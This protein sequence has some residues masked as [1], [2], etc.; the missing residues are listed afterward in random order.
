MFYFHLADHKG[1][2]TAQDYNTQQVSTAT[3]V[4][5]KKYLGIAEIVRALI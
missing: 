4:L 2:R 3:M 1:H 5:F